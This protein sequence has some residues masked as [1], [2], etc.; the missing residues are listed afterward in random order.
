[1]TREQVAEIIDVL[2]R[3]RPTLRAPFYTENL[4]DP[5]KLSPCPTVVLPRESMERFRARYAELM[6][7]AAL[8]TGRSMK[9]VTRHDMQEYLW[10]RAV[11]EASR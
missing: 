9:E 8:V 7:F 11:K 3:T 5:A 4:P 6:V 10:S 2:E 1:M